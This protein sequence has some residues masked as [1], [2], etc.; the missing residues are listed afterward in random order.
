MGFP[1]KVSRHDAARIHDIAH[2]FYG[3]LAGSSLTMDRA[4]SNLFGWLDQPAHEIWAMGTINPA[5]VVGLKTKGVMEVGA[6]ADL[7]LWDSQPSELKPL[8]TWVRG[9][10][11]YECEPT[12]AEVR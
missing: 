8:R 4:M 5:R 3:Q 10:L 12:L 2:P 9:K 6:D 11:V 7:V 1:V